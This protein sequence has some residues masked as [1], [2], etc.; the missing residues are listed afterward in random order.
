MVKLSQVVDG[1]IPCIEKPKDTTEGAMG[2]INKPRKAQNIE[3]THKTLAFYTS[4]DKIPKKE[5]MKADLLK[6]AKSIKIKCTGE[7]ELKMAFTID[8]TKHQ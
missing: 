4:N 5:I 7:I 6:I 8:I 2:L 3:P 1:I